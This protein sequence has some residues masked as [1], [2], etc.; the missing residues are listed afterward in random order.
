MDNLTEVKRS[1]SYFYN[2]YNCI[3][4]LMN[5]NHKSHENYGKQKNKITMI[6]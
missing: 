3:S 1:F 2:E 4:H 5:I 6:F